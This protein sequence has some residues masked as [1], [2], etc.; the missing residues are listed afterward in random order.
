[1]T[2]RYALGGPPRPLRARPPEGETVYEE[3]RFTLKVCA[4]PLSGGG[5]TQRGLIRHPGSVVILP[6][7]DDGGIVL[8]RNTRWQIGETLL[9]VPAGTLEWGEDPR[10]GAARELTE[11]TGYHASDWTP[12]ASFFAAPGVSDEL[13]HVFVARALVEVGQQLAPDERIE[14]VTCSPDEA[15]AAVLDGRIADAK[16]IAVLARHLLA[17]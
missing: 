11:E 13:M 5:E 15:R 4:V 8:I 14:V 2:G 3:A 1:M 12:G 16:S 7:L 10:A 9:E 6:I 17:A